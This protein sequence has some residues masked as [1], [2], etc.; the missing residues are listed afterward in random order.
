MSQ[1]E[2]LLNSMTE[3]EASSGH[4][5][6]VTDSDTYFVIDPINREIE[7]TARRKNMLMQ[8]DHKSERFTFD[9][10]RYVEGHDMSLCNRVRLHWINIDEETGEENSDVIELTDLMVNPE[11]DNS[12]ICSWLITRKS[13]QLVGMLSF[14]IQYMC[15][16]DDGNVEYEWWTDIYSDIEIKKSFNNSEQIAIEYSDVLEQ[17]RS[18]LLPEAIIAALDRAKASGDFN[19]ADGVDGTSVTVV[20]VTE[21]TEDGGSNIVTFSDG[22]TV[23]IK[24]G[25][26]GEQGPKGEK[27]DKGEIGATGA[28]G[29]DGYTPQKNVDYFDGKDGSSVTVVS[30]TESIEDNG[31]NVVTFSDGKAITIKNGSKG[32]KGD[33]GEQGPKGDTGEHGPK[34]DT[35]EQ[36]PKGEKG[37]KGE[38]GAT[39]AD[40]KTPVKGTDYYTETDKTE[41]VNLVLSALPTWTGGNY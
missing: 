15:I 36:G 39:G 11:N 31:S 19:G 38:I 1:S 40:G 9:L 24:N 7:N 16:S 33:T 28:D 35:G 2:E 27:G 17:W 34:G 29:K 8:R 20:S 18:N 26:A 3:M 22:N 23:V 14:I 32:S 13:T 12:V 41:M 6:T 21:S 30:V 4:V 5:H 25:N 10:A 37:D